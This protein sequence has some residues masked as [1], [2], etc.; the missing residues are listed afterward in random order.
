MLLQG[1]D[2]LHKPRLKAL[3][4]RHDLSRRL[5]LGPEKMLRRPEL[6]EGESRHLYDTVVQGR[7]K[8][9]VAHSRD[10]ISDLIQ[11]VAERELRRYPRDGIARRLRGERRGTGDAGIDLDHKVAK[12]LRIQGELDIAAAR[13]SKLC[14]DAEGGAPQKLVFPVR[15]GLRGGADDGIPGVHADRVEIF[16]IADADRVSRTVPHELVLDLLP[17]RDA[18][19]HQN[20]MD[21]GEAKTVFQ[22]LP[23]LLPLLRDASPGAPQR[24]GRAEDD[25]IADL[26]R[27]KEPLRDGADDS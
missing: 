3:R 10:L 1:A 14:D 20:L 23:A 27:R 22:D 8:G 11:R 15:E 17:A 2:R 24:I 5:H 6:V 7:L 21:S 25:G 19:L 13:D 4:D 9:G 26:F 16:H 12:A 18:L